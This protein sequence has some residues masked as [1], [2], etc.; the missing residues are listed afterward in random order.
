M[1]KTRSP[2]YPSASLGDAIQSAK[3][4]Y[5]KAQRA[6]VHPEDAVKAMG[7]EGMSG[8]ARSRL[9]ALRKFG[10]LEDTK[11]GV[12]LTDPALAILLLP[13][14]E[15]ERQAAVNAAAMAPE[16]FREL[17]AQYRDADASVI[18]PY[19]VRA[20]KFSAAGAKQAVDAFQA[21]LALV[22]DSDSGYSSPKGD[23][24]ETRPSVIEHMTPA[25]R[26]AAPAPPIRIPLE[27]N[28]YATLSAPFPLSEAAWLQMMAVLNAMKA[29]LVA[30]PSASGDPSLATDPE[31]ALRRATPSA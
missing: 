17:A 22:S 9:S 13:E 15:P 10:L 27:A 29:G 14:G 1:A 12:R 30:K 4:F 25:D 28:A 8:A 21:T 11:S 20:K 2:N 18:A 19:L 31:D 7:Y 24:T 23:S 26:S 6:A 5:A 16:L 3:R